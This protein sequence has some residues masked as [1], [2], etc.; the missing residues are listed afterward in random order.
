MAKLSAH[1]KPLFTFFSPKRRSLLSIHPDGVTLYRNLSTRSWKV[2]S[3]KKPEISFEEWLVVK[4][5]YFESLPRWAQE[6]K[7]LPSMASLERWMC[8]GI[9]ES[10]TGDDVEPDGCGS[11]GAPSWLLALGMI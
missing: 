2:L 5:R 1:G 9:C 6:T 8:D 7:H 3:R 11:D 10:V 4:R